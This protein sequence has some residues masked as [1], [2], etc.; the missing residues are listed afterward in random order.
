[1]E[2]TVEV[3]VQATNYIERV[4]KIA[5]GGDFTVARERGRYWVAVNGYMYSGNTLESAMERAE[6]HQALEAESVTE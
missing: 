1:M 3:T 6:K 5:N 4:E 2:V